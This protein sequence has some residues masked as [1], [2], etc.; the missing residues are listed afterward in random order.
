MNFLRI[1]NACYTILG[2]EPS[3]LPVLVINSSVSGT[4]T[5]S[6]IKNQREFIANNYATYLIKP[7][8]RACPGTVHTFAAY[9]PESQIICRK[10][11]KRQTNESQS[12]T[13]HLPTE[14]ISHERVNT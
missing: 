12:P 7:G 4:R 8:K 14:K 5:I 3:Q 6:R 2:V 13:S 9:A 1:N 11:K 10:E